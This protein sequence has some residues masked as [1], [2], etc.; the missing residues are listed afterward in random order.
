MLANPLYEDG[1]VSQRP[2]LITAPQFI[3]GGRISG[4]YPAIPVKD[5]YHFRADIGCQNQA[6]SCSILFKLEFKIDNGPAHVYWAYG[7][8]FDGRNVQV[9]INLILLSGENVSF[10]LTAYSLGFPNE[11]NRAVW[12]APRIVQSGII[13]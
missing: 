6:T 3:Y 9:D 5:G 2:G 10:G 7:K 4:F 8:Q 11:E 1:A 13:P 12:I